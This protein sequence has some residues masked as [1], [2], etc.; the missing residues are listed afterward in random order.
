MLVVGLVAARH[1]KPL[2]QEKEVTVKEGPSGELRFIFESKPFEYRSPMLLNCNRGMPVECT[3]EEECTTL[4][5]TYAKH[6]QTITAT[7]IQ[8]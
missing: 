2:H 1:L 4:L 6:C 5:K 8:K 7:R 3:S